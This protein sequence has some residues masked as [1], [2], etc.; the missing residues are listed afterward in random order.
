MAFLASREFVNEA[1]AAGYQIVGV[2][3]LRA[4]R[5][6][7]TLMDQA[8]AIT[9]VMIQSRALIGAADVQDLAEIVCL[10][11]PARAVL[12]AHSGVFSATA[13]Q[14]FTELNE[15]R[16]RLSTTFPQ[17]ARIDVEVLAGL[18]PITEN[19]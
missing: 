13:Q 19:R 4:N 5:L 18:K 17:A 3:Q 9:I 8:E 7:M 16:L 2:E 10:R 12:L 15:P 14:T 11:H 1:R 6:L